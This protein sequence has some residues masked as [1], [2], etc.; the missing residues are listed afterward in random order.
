M[1]WA[2]RLK[3]P[4]SHSLAPDYT[5]LCLSPAPACLFSMCLLGFEVNSVQST[6]KQTRLLFKS[7]RCVIYVK[8]DQ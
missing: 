2:S 8:S 4:F 5:A 3:T 7:S 6:F 1:R